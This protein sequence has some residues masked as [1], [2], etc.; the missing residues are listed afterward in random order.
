MTLHPW[1]RQEVSHEVG[2]RVV[3]Q[4]S[5]SLSGDAQARMSGSAQPRPK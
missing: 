1:P 3:I 2:L 4:V 5:K